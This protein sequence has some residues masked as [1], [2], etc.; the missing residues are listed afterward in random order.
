MKQDIYGT[1]IRE[2]YETTQEPLSAA[3]VADMIGSSKTR[4]YTWVQRN[5]GNLIAMERNDK[6][7]VTYLY[8]GNPNAPSTA[9]T[10]A[11]NPTQTDGGI[12]VGTELTVIGVRVVPGGGV[13]VRLQDEHG[14]MLD[15]TLHI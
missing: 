7:G 4:V 8:R 14:T 3:E 2:I 12:E 6:G 13:V 10:A 1:Q 15:A 5:R 11:S 9:P